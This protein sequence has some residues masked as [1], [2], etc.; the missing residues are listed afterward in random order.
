MSSCVLHRW[1]IYGVHLNYYCVSYEMVHYGEIEKASSP[2]KTNPKISGKPSL[3]QWTTDFQPNLI[4]RGY[5]S[6]LTCLQSTYIVLSTCLGCSWV[7]M[8]CMWLEPWRMGIARE[9]ILQRHC[10]TSCPCDLL[11]SAHFLIQCIFVEW[12][13]GITATLA[14]SL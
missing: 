12:S 4:C 9:R 1:F 8:C 2:S 10:A 13:V 3:C 7:I 11:K 5:W 14:I 6:L